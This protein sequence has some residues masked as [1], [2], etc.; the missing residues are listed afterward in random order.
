MCIFSPVSSQ[1]DL[2][3][4]AVKCLLPV[5]ICPY[6]MC[7]CMFQGCW[8]FFYVCVYTHGVYLFAFW[9]FACALWICLHVLDCLPPGSDLYLHLHNAEFLSFFNYLDIQ[10]PIWSLHIDSPTSTEALPPV[11]II[12]RII[13]IK[14]RVK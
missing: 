11:H 1:H 3:L 7:V 13:L 5:P 4:K 14:G 12:I 6:S 2:P 9:V 10:T 8:V